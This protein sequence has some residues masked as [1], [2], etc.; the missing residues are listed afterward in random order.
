MTGCGLALLL[1]GAGMPR[2]AAH[3]AEVVRGWELS[4]TRSTW[5]FLPA[6]RLFDLPVADSRAPLSGVSVRAAQVEGGVLRWGTFQAI[7]A[8]LAADVPLVEWGAGLK[9]RASIAA[10]AHM[11]FQADAQL[12]FGLRTFDGVFAFPLDFGWPLD[13][14]RGDWSCRFQWT[15]VSAHTA[16]GIRSERELLEQEDLSAPWSREYLQLLA[17]PSWPGMRLYGGGR[18]LLHVA[19]D[20]V[21]PPW[22]VH[23]GL[24]ATGL[25]RLAPYTALDVKAYQELGWRPTLA[26]HVGLRLS[27]PSHR[28]RLA[29]AGST[30]TD[31]TGKFFGEEEHYL[32]LTLAV[33]RGVGSVRRAAL[34]GFRP[35]AAYGSG[36]RRKAA[37]EDGAASAE[38][39][40]EEVEVEV[41]VRVEPEE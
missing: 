27:G 29:L 36:E 30:G 5:T 34:E 11:G 25:T 17:G 28:M 35:L 32:G 18:Y 40:Q 14:G 4:T 7:D 10:S 21:V 37:R 9:L 3:A 38:G 39:E 20:E 13:D 22:T 16:D 1:W 23:A 15:H 12:T 19:G 41:E 8:T 33:D 6:G 31:D 26:M 24:E 2:G